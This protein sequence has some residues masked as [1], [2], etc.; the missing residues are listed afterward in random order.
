MKFNAGDKVKLIEDAWNSIPE[1]YF[2]LNKE[3]QILSGPFSS[4]EKC[5]NFM[6]TYYKFFTKNGFFI[7][8]N[9]RKLEKVKTY[10]KKE[11]EVW[12]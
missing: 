11:D 8:K 6:N 1:E 10:V 12:V 9:I 7:L 4:E 2:V 3:N 5:I